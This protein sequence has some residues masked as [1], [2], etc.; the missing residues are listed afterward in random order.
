TMRAGAGVVTWLCAVSPASARSLS[1]ATGSIVA[2]V[3]GRIVVIDSGRIDIADRT[4]PI[5]LPGSATPRERTL[6]VTGDFR[7]TTIA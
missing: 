5:L 7:T 1:A 3:G 4:L 2:I 6:I